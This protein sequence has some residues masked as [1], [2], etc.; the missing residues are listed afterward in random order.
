MMERMEIKAGSQKS[1][2]SPVLSRMF[3]ALEQGIMAVLTVL[4]AIVA[5]LSTWHLIL[6]TSR[7]LLEGQLDPA[8]QGAFQSFFGTIFTVLIA[9]E[10]K[11]SLLTGTTERGSIVRVRS[12]VLI[13]MLATVRKFI[14]LDLAAVQVTETLVLVAAMLAL[15]VVYWLVR[16]QDQGLGLQGPSLDQSA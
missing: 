11:R 12:V 14:I 9:L 3:D 2:T 13:A 5:I 15:G 8:N 16:G 1:Y 6:L 10:F 7:L 4:I